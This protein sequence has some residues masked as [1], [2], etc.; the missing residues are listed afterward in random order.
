MDYN[1]ELDHQWCGGWGDWH[2]IHTGKVIWLPRQDQLY[3][4]HSLYSTEPVA[5]YLIC[6]TFGIW[7]NS[8][9]A[10]I[11]VTNIEDQRFD[12]IEQLLIAFV[13]EDINKRWDG[14]DWV[15]Q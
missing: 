11:D 4:L 8:F 14:S 10:Y 5:Q 7:L 2:D 1:S 3:A 6:R 15:V 13:M 9:R 12:S